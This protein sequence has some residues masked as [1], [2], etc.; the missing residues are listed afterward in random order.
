MSLKDIIDDSTTDLQQLIGD[1]K[2]L[3]A[4]KKNPTIGNKS[5]LNKTLSEEKKPTSKPKVQ[6]NRL[7]TMSS[8]EHIQRNNWTNHLEKHWIVNYVMW[9]IFGNA[10]FAVRKTVISEESSKNHMKEQTLT[11]DVS[12]TRNGKIHPFQC[13]QGVL[14][15]NH[16]TWTILKSF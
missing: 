8:C 16:L 4:V 7:L 10:N 15:V 13:T 11:K 14:M 9:F 2:I 5:V 12:G 6:L 3:M 1:T